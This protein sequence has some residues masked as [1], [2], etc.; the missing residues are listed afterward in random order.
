M[1]TTKALQQAAHAS[2]SAAATCEELRILAEQGETSA[3]LA[4]A[5]SLSYALAAKISDLCDEIAMRRFD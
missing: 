1:S 5:L 4:E 2:M 3:T